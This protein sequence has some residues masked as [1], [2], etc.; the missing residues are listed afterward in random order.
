MRQNKRQVTV[1]LAL[2]FT[3]VEYTASSTSSHYNYIIHIHKP[4]YNVIEK[5]NSN[6]SFNLIKLNS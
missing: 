5:L 1:K 6:S 2:L 4:Q 3:G